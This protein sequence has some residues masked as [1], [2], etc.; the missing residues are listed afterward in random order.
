MGTRPVELFHLFGE[1]NNLAG[2]GPKTISNLKKLSIEKPR[3]FLFTLPFS[4]LDRLPVNSVR[5]VSYTHLTL[6]T[7]RIV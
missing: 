6:P 1:L 7:K 4:V 5:A 3:D 2:I